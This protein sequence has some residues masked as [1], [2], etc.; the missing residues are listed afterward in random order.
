LSVGADAAKAQW[1]RLSS[2]GII[3]PGTRPRVEEKK[4]RARIH[5]DVWRDIVTATLRD[6]NITAKKVVQ[7]SDTT[8]ERIRHHLTIGQRQG[9]SIL[10]LA[11]RIDQLYL[12]E[13]IPNRSEVIART[14]V[15]SAQNLG[16]HAAAKSTGLALEKKW[17]ATND[18]RTR[19]AHAEAGRGSWILFDEPFEVDGEKLMY[20]GD[21]SMGASAE[22]T[23]QCRCTQI[24]RQVEAKEPEPEPAPVA[25]EPEPE[26]LPEP[27]PAP[28]PET[29]VPKNANEIRSSLRSLREQQRKELDSLR[30]GDWTQKVREAKDRHRKEFH[31]AMY[32]QLN[33]VA[34]ASPGR[35]EMKHDAAKMPNS[36]L[37]DEANGW[38][39]GIVGARSIG[40]KSLE[41]DYLPL[42]GRSFC[43]TST[44]EVF[45]DS[46]T[47]SG[48]GYQPEDVMATAIHE[49]GHA[50]ENANPDLETSARAFLLD[51]MN[52]S[53]GYQNITKHNREE[54]WEDKFP[55]PYCGR[56]YPKGGIESYRKNPFDPNADDLYGTEITSMG[57]EMMR[58][59]AARFFDTDP[60]YFGF[61]LRMLMGEY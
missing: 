40:A 10:Q 32:S 33:A 7:V 57:L 11:E 13:I 45:L 36:E 50:M 6:A 29:K 51:R 26:K 30:T 12:D 23:I 18:D 34:K 2:Q 15:I 46:R 44:N 35:I 47:G 5:R 43:R 19:P 9:D 38:L 55:E 1:K 48:W 22:N 37:V 54:V 49:F 4:G 3:P 24:T 53:G 28:E 41:I 52:D 58:R 31:D 20:P 42:K 16:S 17:V 21:S 25:P 27:A 39:Q 59:D 14:E 56:V 8:K 60:G 61:M